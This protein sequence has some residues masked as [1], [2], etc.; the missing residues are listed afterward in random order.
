MLARL[1]L[2]PGTAPSLT[3]AILDDDRRLEVEGLITGLQERFVDLL[4]RR[5]AL[6]ARVRARIDADKLD[7]AKTLLEEL[8]LLDTVQG[9]IYEQLPLQRRAI[10]APDPQVQRKIDKLFD[11]TQQ[12]VMRFLASGEVEQ[13]ERDLNEAK[14]REKTAADGS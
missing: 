6:A 4:A 14:A 1:P 2:L 13:L 10:V 12:V 8:R 7:E 11:D 5:Q 3:A 9:R